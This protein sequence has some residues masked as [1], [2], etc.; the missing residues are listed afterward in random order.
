MIFHIFK[1]S[2]FFSFFFCFISQFI[3]SQPTSFHLS[4]CSFSFSRSFSINY[5]FSTFCKTSNLKPNLLTFYIFPLIVPPLVLLHTL[6][7]TWTSTTSLFYALTS[8]LDSLNTSTWSFAIL[9]FTLSTSL[10]RR[11]LFELKGL[12]IH[13]SVSFQ[14]FFLLWAFELKLD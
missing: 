11:L 5:W 10:I 3:L 12:E 7:M 2:F 13:A 1:I 9:M 14:I 8:S 4:Q 6:R